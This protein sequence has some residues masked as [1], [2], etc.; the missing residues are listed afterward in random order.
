MTERTNT[1]VWVESRKRWQINVQKDKM[2]RTFV[3]SKPGRAGQSEA[4]A[5]ADEW[6]N[7]LPE[8]ITP[9]NACM[10]DVIEEREASL[11]MRTSWETGIQRTAACRSG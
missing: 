3:S 5:K 2:R 4:N 6:L 8:E 9:T 7:N 1:A 11:K 10:L